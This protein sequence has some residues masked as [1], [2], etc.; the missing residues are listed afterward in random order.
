MDKI[1]TFLLK[2]A[3]IDIENLQKYYDSQKD[4]VC[5]YVKDNIEKYKYGVLLDRFFLKKAFNLEEID[6]SEEEQKVVDRIILEYNIENKEDRIVI[7][8]KLNSDIDFTDYEMNPQVARTTV[9]KLIQQP[10][11]LNESMIMMLLV[12]YED[13]I[14]GVYRYLLESYPQ[15]YLSEKSITYSELVSFDSDLD[16][17]KE[18]FINKE[19]EEFMRLPLSDWYKS[20]ENMHKA[21]FYFE[22]NEFSQFKEI[23][24]RRNLVVHNQGIV[25]EVYK[26]NIPDSTLELG[27]RLC[28]NEDYLEQAFLIARKVLIG[29]VWGLR[30]TADDVDELNSYLFDYGYECLKNEEWELAEYIYAMLLTEE[31]QQDIDK[32]C[33]QVNLWIALKNKKGLDTIETEVRKLDVSA[34]N[35]QFLIA[36][37]ALL[38][39]FDTVSEL[40]ENAIGN[41]FPAW[42]IKEWPLL[43]QY[44]ESAQYNLFV[45]Q[46]KDL[47]D[48]KGYE[49]SNETI[50]DSE[51]V[52]N[53]L[54]ENIDINLNV[55]D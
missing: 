47:F 6:I 5:Q 38:N 26:K 31:K 48:T 21:K 50:G 32:M 51:D 2:D 4:F 23:Y 49:S 28:V 27:E 19:V 55:V 3:L 30:K 17:I 35:K 1:I 10:N 7:N 13:A 43:N 45:E 20:F 44:R 25:N 53:E 12:K 37:H 16:E 9:L 42:C 34:M 54:G 8:Y 39:E 14:A 22:N 36:K 33:E 29:T 24:Y 15:A 41:E 18:K 40:L 11:I 46:H 52:I